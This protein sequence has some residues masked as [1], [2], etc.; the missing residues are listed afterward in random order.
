VLIANTGLRLQKAAP[1]EPCATTLLSMVAAYVLLLCFPQVLF[2]HVVSYRNFTVYSREP[3][4]QNIYAVLDRVESRL[5]ASEIRNDQVKPKI[6]SYQQF[7]IGII[8]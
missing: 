2:G 3:L 7:R 6:F 1:I 8:R 5:A 4:D